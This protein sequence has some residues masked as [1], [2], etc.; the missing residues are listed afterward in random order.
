MVW[1]KQMEKI[2]VL[3]KFNVHF[4]VEQGTCKQN[5]HDLDDLDRTLTMI[6]HT[7]KSMKTFRRYS[8]LK[9]ARLS[10]SM[11]ALKSIWNVKICID[12]ETGLQLCSDHTNEQLRYLK[13]VIWKTTVL[14]NSIF[15]DFWEKVL[16]WE[17]F[18]FRWKARWPTYILN[19]CPLS[20]FIIYNKTVLQINI[21]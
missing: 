5:G 20:N 15:H 16:S 7:C 3:R 17:L 13:L 18:W 2:D 14:W 11:G 19:S 21:T 6:G 12:C 8:F 4:D 1:L 9:L 10:Q